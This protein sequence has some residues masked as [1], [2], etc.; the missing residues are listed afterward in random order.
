MNNPL[1]NRPM[2]ST[3]STTSTIPSVVSSPM[4]LGA[5]VKEVRRN[6][7]LCLYCGESGYQVANCP[8]KGRKATESL[9]SIVVQEDTLLYSRLTSPPTETPNNE[10]PGNPP[11]VFPLA[12][13][14]QPIKSR[15]ANL[16]IIP[17]FVSYGP[18]ENQQE[19]TEAMLDTGASS[20]SI[21][22]TFVDKLQLEYFSC[23]P[24]EELLYFFD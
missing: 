2:T 8:N 12:T 9:G 24:G 1:Q 15:H 7:G 17:V 14:Q 5:T 21:S 13:I 3:P 23:P 11:N 18:D 10:Y 16:I 20:N 6:N 4:E 22:R 19:P